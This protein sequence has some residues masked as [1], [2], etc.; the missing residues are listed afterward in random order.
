M[1]GTTLKRMSAETEELK[2]IKETLPDLKRM[3]D[4]QSLTERAS[5]MIHLSIPKITIQRKQKSPTEEN[6]EGQS[7]H[8]DTIS[9]GIC[10]QLTPP[11][12]DKR[13]KV[14]IEG[15]LLNSMFPFRNSKADE[16]KREDQQEAI[17][18]KMEEEPKL[19]ADSST[20]SEANTTKDAVDCEVLDSNSLPNPEESGPVSPPNPDILHKQPVEEIGTSPL[21]VIMDANQEKEDC[22]SVSN[23]CEEDKQV[24]GEK[25][26]LADINRVDCPQDENKQQSNEDG[27]IGVTSTES[28]QSESSE[29]VPQCEETV[30]NNEL[31]S[32][33]HAQVIESAGCDPIVPENAIDNPSFK[34][35]ETNVTNETKETDELFET[36]ENPETNRVNEEIKAIEM[37]DETNGTNGSNEASEAIETNHETKEII[38][39][40]AAN[41]NGLVSDEVNK[42]NEVNEVVESKETSESTETIEQCEITKTKMECETDP[43]TNIEPESLALGSSS[44]SNQSN[45]DSNNTISKDELNVVE[46]TKNGTVECEST[47]ASVNSRSEIDITVTNNSDLNEPKSTVDHSST[48]NDTDLVH[49]EISKV[50]SQPTLETEEENKSDM[51]IEEVEK[52]SEDPSNVDIEKEEKETKER[53]IECAMEIE[54]GHV[55]ST[56]IESNKMEEENGVET[57]ELNRQ[58]ENGKNNSVQK[59]SEIEPI[60]EMKPSDQ[61]QSDNT[62]DSTC[63]VEP[64][65]IDELLLESGVADT[66]EVKCSEEPISLLPT[67]VLSASDKS[68]SCSKIPEPQRVN[69]ESNDLKSVANS[70]IQ[71]KSSV[72][73]EIKDTIDSSI[74]NERN[75]SRDVNRPTDSPI[76][77]ESN[78]PN[79]SLPIESSEIK[80]AA[81][82]PIPTELNHFHSCNLQVCNQPALESSSPQSSPND[83]PSPMPMSPSVNQQSITDFFRVTKNRSPISQRTI[84]KDPAPVSQPTALNPSTNESP[85]PSP[86]NSSASTTKQND[87]PQPTPPL[88]SKQSVSEPFQPSNEPSSIPLSA[89]NQSKPSSVLPSTPSAPFKPPRSIESSSSSHPPPTSSI[90][91]SSTPPQLTSVKDLPLSLESKMNSILNQL[92]SQ[93]STCHQPYRPV[94]RQPTPPPLSPPSLPISHL[95]FVYISNRGC[96]VVISHH[97]H[98]Q[99]RIRLLI[100]YILHT[101]SLLRHHPVLTS[102][103]L[104]VPEFLSYMKEKQL[105]SIVIPILEIVVD[106]SSLLLL[107]D[108]SIFKS[109]CSIHLTIAFF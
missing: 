75:D 100:S 28:N 18:V 83:S 29:P 81:E 54:D 11:S 107:N 48:M 59:P 15:A 33:Q 22:T 102:S 90:P 86:F 2:T 47:T 74:H 89:M 17:K 98:P 21:N 105:P 6:Q 42:A 96:A 24:V 51:D 91:P 38:E 79:H 39:I 52:D 88:P 50:F 12:P 34:T 99:D 87:H 14:D 106:G 64:K 1:S 60:N 72:L 84:Q 4:A 8:H 16:V 108:E 80:E 73:A 68:D 82:S 78:G 71:T 58:D 25:V 103:M 49:S 62:P 44:Q 61:I 3:V 32:D 70:P 45:E 35:E 31:D 26:E 77:S 36:T 41:K 57:V 46:S 37:N 23:E 27:N 104:P 94:S 92:D 43:N 5:K 97:F 76:Q 40:T 109:D 10:I 95:V 55:E 7:E 30:L 101:P 66:K 69:E 85:T 13:R 20:V 53:A 9:T 67:A 19:F 63:N 93:L 56:S 65:Q